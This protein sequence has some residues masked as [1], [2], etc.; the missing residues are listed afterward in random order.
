MNIL[1]I[2]HHK[3]NLSMLLC[4]FD[5]INFTS[6]PD[7]STVESSA[8]KSTIDEFWMKDDISLMYIRKSIGPKIDNYASYLEMFKTSQML[9]K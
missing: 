2:V 6:Y 4:K 8:Y 9:T 1:F 7:S 3:V 5:S